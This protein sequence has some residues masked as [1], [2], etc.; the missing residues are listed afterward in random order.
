M[1]DDTLRSVPLGSLLQITYQGTKKTANLM[2]L[3]TFKVLADR[4]SADS[5]ENHLQS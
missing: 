2:D 5:L 3:K 1:L 4:E